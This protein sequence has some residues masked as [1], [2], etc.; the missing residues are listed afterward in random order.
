ME[1]NK[2]LTAI[3]IVINHTVV[4]FSNSYYVHTSKFEHG[5]DRSKEGVKYGATDRSKANVR[6]KKTKQSEKFRLFWGSALIFR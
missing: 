5:H 4:H 2:A 6:L 3:G 1:S